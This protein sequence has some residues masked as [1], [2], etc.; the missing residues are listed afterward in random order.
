MTLDGH[1]ERP[2]PLPEDQNCVSC[3]YAH[4]ERIEATARMLGQRYEQDAVLKGLKWDFPR[5]PKPCKQHLTVIDAPPRDETT[6]MRAQRPPVAPP[7]NTGKVHPP[8]D[9]ALSRPLNGQP[10]EH[11]LIRA[12]LPSGDLRAM[13]EATRNQ[14]RPTGPLVP[15]ESGKQEV[16]GWL[17][18]ATNSA[19]LFAKPQPLTIHKQQCPECVGG[20]FYE[21]DGTFGPCANCQGTGW[22]QPQ[23]KPDASVV[24]D[25][26]RLMMPPAER[27]AP[28]A[29]SEQPPQTGAMP[30]ITDT[31]P[32]AFQDAALLEKARERKR[33]ELHA[34]MQTWAHWQIAEA[35]THADN[36]RYLSQG[37]ERA[38]ELI[39]EMIEHDCCMMAECAKRIEQRLREWPGGEKKHAS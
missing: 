18:G 27:A 1:Q 8:R 16:P 20:T 34:T 12:S 35:Q 29:L 4:N 7:A 36:V 25:R 6:R 31:T 13:H 9:R 21:P 3:V 26:Y 19:P 23:P 5:H 14:W 38:E 33:L 32:H 15:S 10:P 22:I 39:G 2:N 28:M 30:A 17:L 11:H 24:A 37:L